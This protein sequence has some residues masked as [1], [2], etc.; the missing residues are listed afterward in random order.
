LHFP[1]LKDVRVEANSLAQVVAVLDELHP[2]LADYLIDER[3]ALRR[4]VNIFINDEL[5]DDRKTLRDKVSAGDRV[6]IMQA[7]SGG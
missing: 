7:L 4:H 1:D 6:F 2:G 5:L 3:G